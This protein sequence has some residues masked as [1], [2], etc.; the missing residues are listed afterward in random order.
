MNVRRTIAATAATVMLG[1][2]LAL[3]AP[4]A[5]AAPGTPSDVT[6]I[7]LDPKDMDAK[8]CWNV[9]R[10][11]GGGKGAV[12]LCRTGWGLSIDGWVQDTSAD[13]KCAQLYGTFNT[14]RAWTSPRACPKGSKP[15]FTRQQQGATNS[16]VLLRV[17]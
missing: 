15:G 12:T 13:D 2:G 6:V 16:T 14:G 8:G 7:K 9:S 11:V 1:G 3:A 17:F 4:A 5:S 10:S